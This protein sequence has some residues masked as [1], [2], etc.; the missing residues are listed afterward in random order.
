[1]LITRLLHLTINLGF[2]LR[3]KLRLEVGG[4]TSLKQIFIE[5]ILIGAHQPQAITSPITADE[6]AY[7]SFATSKKKKKK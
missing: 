7:S 5:E 6:A 1:M 3:K 4:G 2:S